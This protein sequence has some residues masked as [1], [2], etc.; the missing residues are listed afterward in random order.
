VDSIIALSIVTCPH[1]QV[2][3]HALQNVEVDCKLTR[4]AL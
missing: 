3:L 2:I 4:A 1:G